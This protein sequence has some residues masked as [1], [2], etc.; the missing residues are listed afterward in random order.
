MRTTEELLTQYA[1]YHRD[2]R[3]IATHFLGVPIIVFSV[4]L[5]FAQILVGPIHLGW[6][7]VLTA[8]AYYLSLDRQLGLLMFGFLA[9]CAVVASAV[10]FKT[11]WVTGLGI[12]VVLFVVGWA[13]QFVG[14]QY[15]GLKPAFVDDLIGLAVGPLFVLVEFLFLLKM[16]QDLK[17]YIETRVGPTLAARNGQPLTP[18]QPTTKPVTTS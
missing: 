13:I 14:H 5:G 3:N 17:R 8:S 1:A 15:E 7:L 16:R 2:R 9:L 10:S 12:A 4:I 11:G 6:V 18:G